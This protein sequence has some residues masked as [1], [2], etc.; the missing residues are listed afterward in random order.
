VNGAALGGGFEL[1]LGCDLVVAA[2]GAVFGCPE[3]TRGLFATSGGAL[4][5]P[6]TI[7]RVR[8]MELLLT[9]D[10]VDAGTALALGLVNRVVPAK[11]LIATTRDLAARICANAPLAVRQTLATAREAYEPTA[12]QWSRNDAAWA[13]IAATEDAREGPLAFAEKRPPRWRGR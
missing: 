1:V 2:E 3:V 6:T 13:R 11:R 7:P 10:P 9:G 8:A 4:R 12:A 5:L